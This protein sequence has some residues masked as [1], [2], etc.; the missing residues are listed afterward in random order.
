MFLRL[1]LTA[2]GGPAAHIA[3]MEDEIVRRRQWVSS[4]EF[5]DMLSAANVMPGPNSTELAIH[6][7]YRRAGMR[8]LLA[9]GAAFIVPATIMVW[10]L[11]MAYVQYGM[12][13]E[14]TAMLSGMQPVVLAVVAHALW[15]LRVSLIRSRLRLAIAVVGTISVVAGVHELVVLALAALVGLA[16]ATRWCNPARVAPSL[17]T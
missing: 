7:G 5:L 15:R 6:L 12:R 3:V 16:S 17:V 2:F 4:R 10:V 8:G 13:P 11:A 14:V 1:G 9:A